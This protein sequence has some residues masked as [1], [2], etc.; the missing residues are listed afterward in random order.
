MSRK[1]YSDGSLMVH[2]KYFLQCFLL[3]ISDF[4]IMPE[5]CIEAWDLCVGVNGFV[6]NSFLLF[7]RFCIQRDRAQCTGAVWRW[8]MCCD[9]TCAGY[10]Y[11]SNIFNNVIEKF[12]VKGVSI[13]IE[14]ENMIVWCYKM[15][16]VIFRNIYGS[17]TRSWCMWCSKDL[18]C[19]LIV[20]ND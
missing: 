5:Y 9:C 16:L 13:C 1:Q 3:Y 7:C 8:T 11:S 18:L 20:L 19:I 6:N 2:W 12:S 15:D 17:T 14:L 10:N 4:M